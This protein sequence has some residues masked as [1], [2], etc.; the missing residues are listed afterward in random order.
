[1]RKL[2]IIGIDGGTLDLI[3]IFVKDGNLPLF[4]KFMKEGCFGE[5]KSTTPAL[6]PPA[7]ISSFT[8]VNPGKHNIFDFFSFDRK[9]KSLKLNTSLNRKYPCFWEIISQFGFKVGLY[10]VPCCYPVDKVEGFMVSG[11]TTPKNSSGFAYPEEVEKAI[12]QNKKKKFGANSLLLE[13]GK[14]EEFLKDIYKTT[15]IDEEIALNLI[16]KFNPQVMMYIFDE[17]DRVMHFFWR[18]FDENHPKHTDKT[19][20]KNAVCDYYKRIEKGIEKFTKEFGDC[21][22]L[23]YSDHGFGPLYK[24]VYVNRL[25]WEWGYLKINQYA[26]EFAQK[27]FY[28]RVLKSAIPPQIRKFYREKIKPSPLA[29]PLGYIDFQNSKAVYTS[30]SGR[31]IIILDEENKEKIKRELKEKLENYI[32]KETKIKPFKQVFAKEEIYSGDYAQNAP[33]L[34]IEEDGRYAFKTEWSLCEIKDSSQYGAVKS[35]SHREKGFFI[36]NGKSFEK[37]R[38]IEN[39]EIVDICP[40]ILYFLGV[41][42]GT[43][44]DGKVLAECF[45]EKKESKFQKYSHLRSGEKRDSDID[46]EEIKEKLKNLGYM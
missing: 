15:E 14:R 9:E 8:G 38:K 25:L 19:P 29:N 24:D 1:L 21:D 31:S 4:E 20:F 36:L 41:P 10:N 33:D 32:D 3:N 2:L 46:E 12:N 44:M 43:E 28:K 39:A 34:V 11:M 37:G 30:V 18:D 16:R 6:T 7:W 42:L 27:P 26:K 13:K 23:I 40:T 5:L 35:G 22:I 45:K 17:S